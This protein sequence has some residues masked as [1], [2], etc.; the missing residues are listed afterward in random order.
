MN[1]I[2]TS[3]TILLV[4]YIFVRLAK[5]IKIPYVVALICSGIIWGLPA[6]KDVLI[7]P[8]TQLISSLGDIGL[9]SL[10]FLAGAGSSLKAM[11]K[12]RSD[13]VIIAI[14]ATLVPLFLGFAVFKL[15][16][17][18]FLS[19]FIVG[20]C[21]SITAEATTSRVLIEL[22][23]LK[24]RVGAAMTEAGIVDDIIGLS[25]FILVTYL[26]KVSYL[27]EDLLIAGAILSFFIGILFQKRFQRGNS[28]LKNLEKGML[29]LVI[30]F[31]FVSMGLNF[32]IGSLFV[33]PYWIIVLVIAIGGKLI[34]TLII[35]PFTKFS[36][37]KL[38]LVGWGMNSRGA[39]ELAIALIAFRSGLIPTELYSSLVIMALF[40]TLLFPFIIIR[41][42]KKDS[43]IMN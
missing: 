32:D 14:S 28:I 39:V 27:K 40:T 24:T 18:S 36:W 15:M 30:P 33:N 34:G 2:I 3:I 4:S 5:T 25:L 10:M 17:F 21:M 41:M 26:L 12:E 20:I 11:Y 16:G 31:F 42:I 19:S 9:I 6:I 37:K 22:N 29:I 8:D 38:Y 43:R 1:L 13:A 23:K 7:G 35:K